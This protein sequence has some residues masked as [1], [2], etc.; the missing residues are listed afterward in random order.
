MKVDLDPPTGDIGN[1][2]SLVLNFCSHT[3]DYT[4]KK[5]DKKIKGLEKK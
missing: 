2:F 1:V 5:S 3:Y 4:E